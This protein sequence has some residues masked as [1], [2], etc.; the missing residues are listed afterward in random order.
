MVLIVDNSLGDVVLAKMAL[1]ATGRKTSFRSATDGKSALAALRNDHLL[2]SLVL[3]DL[4]L[5]GMDGLEVLR[6]IRIDNDPRDLPV[7]VI[8][9]SPLE[10]DKAAAN[11]AGANS[12]IQKPFC[13]D[14]YSRDL[15]SVLRRLVPDYT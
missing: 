8:T 9:S 3:L 11:A 13:L 10:S 7:V 15:E 4:K 5:P 14:Q 1:R 12:Y 6:E 2:P